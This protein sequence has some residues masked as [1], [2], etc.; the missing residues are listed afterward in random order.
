[1]HGG[2]AAATRESIPANAGHAVGNGDRGQT[3]T[4]TEGILTDAGHAVRDGDRGQGVAS[5]ESPVSDAGH[6]AGNNQISNLRSIQE[7]VMGMIKW[8]RI[9][10]A[11]SYFAPCL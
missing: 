9:D 6:A 7:K 3:T 4:I 1:M 2:Q 5:T 11:I 8:I 10:I